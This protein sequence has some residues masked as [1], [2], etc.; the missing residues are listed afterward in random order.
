MKRLYGYLYMYTQKLIQNLGW[1]FFFSGYLNMYFQKYFT[2]YPFFWWWRGKSLSEKVIILRDSLSNLSVS[3]TKWVFT[4]TQVLGEYAVSI[5]WH[6]RRQCLHW[7]RDIPYVVRGV[8]C[9]LY[10]GH[11][12]T[13]VTANHRSQPFTTK[14]ALFFAFR[15]VRFREK[16]WEK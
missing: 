1:K 15:F 10:T 8:E 11:A 9:Q 14:P 12:Y 4:K 16:G 5:Y 2:H 13:P 3:Y 6:L 7:A